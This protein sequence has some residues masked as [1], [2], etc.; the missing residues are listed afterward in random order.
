MNTNYLYVAIAVVAVILIAV[1]A[2]NRNNSAEVSDDVNVTAN[3]NTESQDNANT[4]AMNTNGNSNTSSNANTP[5]NSEPTTPDGN[6]VAVFEVTFDGQAFT[7]S[8]LN[9]KQGD[10]VVFRNESSE[11]FWPASGPHPQHTNYP[12]FDPKKPIAAGQTWQFKFAKTG[13]WGFHDHLTPSAT[14]R[15]TVK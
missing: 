8:Q 11:N 12:E 7:P 15:I 13:T 14:G 4:D 10:V 2:L 6:D 9:I 1:F 3:L 5:N